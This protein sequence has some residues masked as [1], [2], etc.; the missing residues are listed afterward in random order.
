[1]VKHQYIL[2]CLYPLMNN[3]FVY[4][5]GLAIIHEAYKACVVDELGKMSKNNS[6]RFDYIHGYTG[7]HALED[8]RNIVSHG[9]KNMD[10]LQ[11]SLD[12]MLPEE[13]EYKLGLIG[14]EYMSDVI[15]RNQEAMVA[16]Y[17]MAANTFPS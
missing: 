15:L 7:D 16:V 17:K 9:Y 13:I 10:S 2:S 4:T 5:H 12:T 1:M 3:P 8:M 11:L 14:C 6:E